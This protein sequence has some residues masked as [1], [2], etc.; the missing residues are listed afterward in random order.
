MNV[1]GT[2]HALDVAA[3]CFI[4]LAVSCCGGR[5]AAETAASAAASEKK[6]FPV[7]VEPR[8]TPS[9]IS[10]WLRGKV[11][12]HLTTQPR[13][14]G[15]QGGDSGGGGLVRLRRGKRWRQGRSGAA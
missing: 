3:V 11:S 10:Q 5:A 1:S 14:L 8:T 7:D 9:S 2:L 12:L 6:T 13:K 15:F 4:V